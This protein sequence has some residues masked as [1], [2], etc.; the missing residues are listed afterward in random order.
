M[1]RFFE[2]AAT[3]GF[4]SSRGF[5]LDRPHGSLCSLASSQDSC[6]WSKSFTPH[7]LEL[8]YDAADVLGITAVD[9]EQS[10][11]GVDQRQ[12]S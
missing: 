12:C 9:D 10:I 4:S 3:Q 5:T 6:R 2:P 11:L 7:D 1:P 8:L